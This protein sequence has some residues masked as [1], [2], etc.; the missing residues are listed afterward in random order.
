[1]PLTR[2]LFVRIF[3]LAIGLVPNALLKV[4]KSA[5]DMHI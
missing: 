3:F 5:V 4:E 1:M 2:L